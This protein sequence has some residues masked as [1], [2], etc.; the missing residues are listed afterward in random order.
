LHRVKDYLNQQNAD[1]R[2]DEGAFTTIR[3]PSAR[4]TWHRCILTLSEGKRRPTPNWH[5]RSQWHT[6]LTS[7]WAFTAPPPQ[8]V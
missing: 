3:D 2:P 1:N 7:F 5:W 4:W 8:A 6:K